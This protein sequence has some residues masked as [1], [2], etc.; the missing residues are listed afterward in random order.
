M[1]ADV[2]AFDQLQPV[3]VVRPGGPEEFARAVTRARAEGFA[4]GR[5][6]GL[7]EAEARVTAAEQALH[8]AAAALDAERTA[9][10]DAVERAAV[11]L[12]LQ[13]AEHAVRAAVAADPER[14]LDAAQGALRALVERQHVLVLVNPE[15]LELVRAGLGPLIAELGGVGHYEVQ[16]ERRV[17]R[18]GAVVRTVD[19]EIDATVETKL[20]RAREAL[21]D[22]LTRRRA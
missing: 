3:A 18:G 8:A 17:T 7:A 15:D 6:A 10:A 19:G 22:E 21:D 14:V 16:A 5:A 1:S 20:T 4:E 12:A 2:V 13:I 11:E 9:V